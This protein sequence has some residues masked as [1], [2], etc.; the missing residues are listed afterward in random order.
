MQILE[1]H[2][3]RPFTNKAINNKFV[4]QSYQNLLQCP[5]RGSIC[6]GINAIRKKSHF[7]AEQNI[8][9]W[10]MRATLSLCWRNTA[11]IMARGA[12][13]VGDMQDAFVDHLE[14]KFNYVGFNLK[15]EYLVCI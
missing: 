1:N 5:K 15:E 14:Y 2:V 9:R 10:P 13:L 7:R 12:I 6:V 3:T 11:L 4:N 8:Q